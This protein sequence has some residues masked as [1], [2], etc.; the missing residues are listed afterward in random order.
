MKKIEIVTGFA[1]YKVLLAILGVVASGLSF[2]AWKWNKEQHQKY[3]FRKEQACQQSLKIAEK[4]V[5]NNQFLRAA[6]YASTTQEK[7]RIKLNQPG[8]TTEFKPDKEYVLIHDKAVALI[9]N[10]PRY[11]GKLF[12]RLSKQPEKY[13]PEP[14][15]VTGNKVLGNKVEVISTCSPQP[16]T[17]SLENLYEIAQPID[18]NPYLPPFSIF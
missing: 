1:N 18:I 8:I 5:Q 13:P 7:L 17:V 14:L 15:M 2:T 9:P 4:Y 11:E 6:Y 12:E 10:N 3:I 16:F